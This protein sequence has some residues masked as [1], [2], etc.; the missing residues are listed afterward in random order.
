MRSL[1]NQVVWITGASSGIGEALAYALSAQGAKLILSSRRAAELERVKSNCAC[2]D[3]V[4]TLP[5][6]LMDSAGLEAKVPAAIA[7]YSV[8]LLRRLKLLFTGK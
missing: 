3:D 2:P 8:G 7:L 6:D 5:L 1:K 4:Y